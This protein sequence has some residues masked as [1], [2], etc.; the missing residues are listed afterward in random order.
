MTDE[1]KQ[2]EEAPA[3]EGKKSG[4]SWMDDTTMIVFFGVIFFAAVL[5]FTGNIYFGLAVFALTLF[6][7]KSVM[8]RLRS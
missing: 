6:F 1:E 4:S 5:Y 7:G 3:P 8:R 2:V